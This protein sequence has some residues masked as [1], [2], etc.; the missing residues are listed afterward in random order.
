MCVCENIYIY[1]CECVCALCGCGRDWNHERCEWIVIRVW[2]HTIR[3]LDWSGGNKGVG[4]CSERDE[5]VA[6]SESWK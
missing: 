6:E 1:V 4:A 3:E 2:L 5:D